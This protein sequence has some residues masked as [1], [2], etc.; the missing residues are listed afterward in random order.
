MRSVRL[1]CFGWLLAQLIISAGAVA[2]ENPYPLRPP[3]LS[4]PRAT[5]QGFIGALDEAYGRFA[6]LISEY[7]ASNRLYFSAKERRR[8]L[9]ALALGLKAVRFM[10]LS[11]V[12]PVL[13]DIVGPDRAIQLKEIFDRIEIPPFEEIP[14][15]AAMERSSAKSWRLPNTGIEIAL[16]ESGPGAGE[17]LITAATVD[18]VPEFYGQVRELPYKPGPA[19][20]LNEAYRLLS[21]SRTFTIHDAYATSPV[22]VSMIVPPRWMLNLPGWAKARIAGLAV[23]QWLAFAFGLGICALLV[24]ASYRVTRWLARRGEV[25]EGVGLHS[26]L[27]PL[28]V[29]AVMAFLIPLLAVVLRIGDTPRIGTELVRTVVLYLAAAWL[30]FVGAGVLGNTLVASG[31]LGVRSLDSQLIK[32]GSRF[33]GIVI[34]IGLLMQGATDLGFPAYSVIAGLGVGGLA[35]ALAARDSL[36]NLLGS[37]LIMFEKPFRVG[38]RIRVSG[39][40]GTVEDVGFRSTWIRTLDN[41]LISIPNNSV[42]NATIENLT[43]RKMFRERLVLQLTYDTPRERLETFARRLQQLIEEHPTTDKTTI[44]VRFND[45]GESSLN[46][47]VIFHLVVADAAAE[48]EERETLLLRFIDLA[49]E[50][51]VEFAFPTRTLHVEAAPVPGASGLTLERRPAR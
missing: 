3:D 22:G 10:D 11:L 48:L 29:V 1:A 44:R 25:E 19:K 21:G 39:N 45:F 2:A 43:L 7:A 14:D 35:V 24:Y 23:W 40:E 42:V 31:Q 37:V 49:Q 36:A 5:L 50:L 26:L 20:Q 28:A 47:L 34:A 46:I 4:S 12:S 16:V 38:H 32:L 51:G 27:T 15:R 30:V 8:Q 18:R 13:H 33:V 6:A 17:Y 41:S 9:A